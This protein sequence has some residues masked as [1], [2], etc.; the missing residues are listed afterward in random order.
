M[1]YRSRERAVRFQVRA[2]HVVHGQCAHLRVVVANGLVQG[3]VGFRRVALDGEACQGSQGQWP[4]HLLT[5]R[6]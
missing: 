3:I 5:P 1:A 2:T 4:A 6:C